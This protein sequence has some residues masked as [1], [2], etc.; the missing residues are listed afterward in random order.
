LA[1]KKHHK[2]TS[3]PSGAVLKGRVEKA[4]GEG[5]FQQGLELAKQL[6][7]SEPT[8]AHLELVKRAYL[9]RARQLRTQ[10]H[11]RDAATVLRA[12]LLVDRTTPAWLEQVAAELVQTGEVKEALALT[13]QAPEAVAGLLG[14]A[15]DAALQ[16]EAAGR[17]ELPESLHADFDRVVQAYK[18]AEAGDDD[19]ARAALQ[20]IGL[21]SPFLEWKVLL[22]GLQAYYAKDDARAM[23]NW[24]R[25]APDRLPA[26][27]AAPFRYHI[28]LEF[29]AAQ[30]PETQTALQRQ[31]GRVEGAATLVPQLRQL[32][33]A[34]AKPDSLAAAYRQAEALLPI[35]QREA[36][37]LVDRLASCFY[38]GALDTGP[39]DV[40][41]YKRVFGRP[42]A[43]PSFFRLEALANDR[44]GNPEEAHMN[45]K[46]Y[47]KEIADD[48]KAWPAGQADRVRAL[49]WL[50]MGRNAAGIPSP[51]EMARLPAFLRDHPDRPRPLKPSAEECF[52]RS[53][54]LAPDLLEAHEALLQMHRRAG[55][56]AKAEKTA[57]ALLK[58][59]PDHLPTLEALSDLLMEKEEYAEALELLQRA[60]KANPL[61]REL[62][63]RVAHVHMLTARGHALADR[64][65][66]A[67]SEYQ[68]ALNLEEPGE[69][70]SVLCRWAAC[71]FRAGQTER[72]EDLLQQARDKAPAP[73]ALSYYMLVETIR[74]KLHRTLKA[75]F[76]KEF[77][78]GLEEPAV[79]AAAAEMVDLAQALMKSDVVYHGLKTHAKK[80]TAYI[81][82]TP[83]GDFTESQL[84]TVGSALVDLNATAAAR[85]FL[86]KAREL[87]ARNPLFPYLEA[88]T[89]MTGDLENVRTYQVKPLLD[90]AR[91]LADALPQDA[92]RDKL[93]Q[94]IQE[95]LAALAAANPYAMMGFMP[96]FFESMFGFDRDDD[97]DYDD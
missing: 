79:P 40:L 92:R 90:E 80:I 3:A 43:D 74:L 18:Q 11:S 72:A 25:L 59:F 35:L 70:Y 1:K 87:F 34:L 31:F 44:A 4:M 94:D 39:D 26:R 15:V 77:K 73:L 30:S 41:R 46:K 36:P 21:R 68:A 51:E 69:V 97:D 78:A 65:D 5:R 89:Y 93:L 91:R 63:S 20:T 86:D 53:L 48:P 38:W 49:I 96:N 64:F 76:E 6:H 82:K 19:G 85:R 67:R 28:D 66:D 45:W 2:F 56:N 54:E 37:E 84:E 50:R 52:R 7:K 27:L 55:Q 83:V 58:Q 42:A 81:E 12:A 95:R 60:W 22:R 14:H 16:K 8:P 17:A 9:G 24:Q 29:R 33:A 62:R 23:E 71:E 88:L 61:N 47:E 10:G 32:R 57:R 13:A 75:R